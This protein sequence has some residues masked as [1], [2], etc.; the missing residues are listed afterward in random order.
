M[1]VALQEKSTSSYSDSI[2]HNR[3]IVGILTVKIQCN[4]C[5]NVVFTSLVEACKLQLSQP[6]PVLYKFM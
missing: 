6:E 2:F 5:Y 4:K 1:I 3:E